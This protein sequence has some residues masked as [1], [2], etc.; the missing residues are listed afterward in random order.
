M[1]LLE[2]ASNVGIPNVKTTPTIHCKA[3]EDNSGALEI[4]KLPKLRP[5]TKHMN[6][7][8]HH[9]RQHVSEK[10]L[11]LVATSTENQLADAMTKPLGIEL[12]RKHRKSIMGW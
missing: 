12:F 5:R 2:E 3:F 1:Q 7:Q 11:S 8:L 6:V 4:A 9:F 10:R